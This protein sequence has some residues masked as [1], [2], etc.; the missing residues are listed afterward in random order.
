MFWFVV[1][2]ELLLLSCCYRVVVVVVLHADLKVV[3]LAE[4]LTELGFECHG[5]ELLYNS[6]TGEQHKT[7]VFMGP[8]F[9]QVCNLFLNESALFEDGWMDVRV[10]VVRMDVHVVVV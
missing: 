6:R 10:V 9:Y 5:N 3:D 2:T 8:T 7:T 4:L 1:V